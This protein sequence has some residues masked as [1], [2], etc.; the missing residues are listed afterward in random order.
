MAEGE[1]YKETNT[2]NADMNRIPLQH[3]ALMAAV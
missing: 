1:L 3:R 2:I